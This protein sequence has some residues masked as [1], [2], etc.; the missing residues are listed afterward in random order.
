M[1]VVAHGH[2]Q[3]DNAFRVVNLGVARSVS[4]G[5]Y[6]ERRVAHE[7]GLL[8]GANTYGTRASEVAAIV[9]SEGGA[10]AAAAA[11]EGVLRVSA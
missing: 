3:P 5:A 10:D 7:L 6:R 4:P 9:R 1:L 11:I 8:L 2:D